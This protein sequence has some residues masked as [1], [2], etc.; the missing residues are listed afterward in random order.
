MIET[1]IDSSAGILGTIILRPNQSFTWRSSKIFLG[2]LMILSM[3]IAITFLVRGYWMILP[4]SLLEVSIV[5]ACFFVILKRT[6][7]QQVIAISQDTIRVEEGAKRPE[8]V[9]AWQRYFTKVVVEPPRYPSY[10]IT[11]KLKHRDH[12]IEL[13]GFL[14]S[15]EKKELVAS[16]SDL[17]HRANHRHA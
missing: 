16:L 2:M 12:E 9:V 4:F 10:S 11:I 15:E 14:N 3:A 5:A 8:K 6:Q 7:Q 13:G 17:I 1:R